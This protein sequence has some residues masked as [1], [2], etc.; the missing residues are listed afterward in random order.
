MILRNTTR[1]VVVATALNQLIYAVR[2][3]NLI[4]DLSACQAQ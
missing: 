1:A 4:E 2:L 3:T